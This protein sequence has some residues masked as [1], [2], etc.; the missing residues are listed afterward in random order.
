MKFIRLFVLLIAMCIGSLFVHAQQT[1]VAFGQNPKIEFR[2]IQSPF[3]TG[4]TAGTIL[5]R[6]LTSGS[7]YQTRAGIEALLGE[8]R[9]DSFIP[10]DIRFLTGGIEM[11]ER[12]RVLHNGRIG[13][14]TSSPEARFE[15]QQYRTSGN[16]IP[17][18]QIRGGTLA[19]PSSFLIE[20]ME[21]DDIFRASLDGE[22][23]I[24]RGNV[25]VEDQ[26]VEITSGRL[27]VNTSDALGNHVA[28]F[29]G[30][31][32]GTEFWVKRYQNWPDYVFASTYELRSLSE[33]KAFINQFGHLPDVPSAR[34]IDINGYNMVDMQALTMRKIEELTL[35][36]IDLEEKHQAE[37]ECLLEIISELADRV[38]VLEQQD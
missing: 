25:V 20:Y 27:L 23:R 29:N 36:M 7:G 6:P 37:K 26:N 15:I 35:H 33:T 1:P 32:L 13:V 10:L 3:T 30:S 2:A 17:L 24:K 16:N 28:L 12:L 8:D 18:F 38:E 19:S 34:W 5:W 31:V 9:D 21:S 4:S 14:N 11:E 22:L